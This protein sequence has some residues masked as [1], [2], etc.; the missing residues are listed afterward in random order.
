MGTWLQSNVTS[1]VTMVVN[2]LVIVVGGGYLIG[3]L[4][5]KLEAFIEQTELQFKHVNQRIDNSTEGRYYAKDAQTQFALRDQRLSTHEDNI[6]RLDREMLSLTK[7]AG[8]TYAVAIQTEAAV[9]ALTEIV[10]RLPPEA[11]LEDLRTLKSQA[12]EHRLEQ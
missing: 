4:S 5:A 2:I 3:N 10:R 8:D 9:H 6:D 11:L 1:L 12:H 7:V